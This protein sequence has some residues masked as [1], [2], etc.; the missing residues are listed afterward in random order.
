LGRAVCAAV[1]LV[2]AGAALA[3]PSVEWTRQVTNP[4]SDFGEAVA[5]DNSGRAYLAGSM[6]T[7]SPHDAFLAQNH[8]N[9]TPQ[10]LSTVQAGVGWNEMGHAAA[11]DG[12][13]NVWL[14]GHVEDHFNVYDGFVYQFDV[15]TGGITH[16]TRLFLDYS[17]V[18]GLCADGSGSAYLVATANGNGYLAKVTNGGI[19]WDRSFALGA[20]GEGL[21][22]ACDGGGN[23]YVA[24]HQMVNYG[25]VVRPDV[26]VEK[27]SS[28]GAPVWS[29]SFGTEWGE[30]GTTIACD[31]FGNVYVGGYATGHFTQPSAGGE[32]AFIL[33]LDAAD[34]TEQWGRQF[35][36]AEDEALWALACDSA[37]VL[38]VTGDT[39]GDL[40]GP[41]L[42][43]TDVFHGLVTPDGDIPWMEQW[44]T[45]WFDSGTGLCISG[46]DMYLAFTAGN[47]PGGTDDDAC[48]SRYLIA[49]PATRGLLALG[50]LALIRRRR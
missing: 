36:T 15:A 17:S 33:K 44:G 6:W 47:R 14:G 41:N 2:S 16:Q 43:Y 9:G 28:S 11:A 39:R 35:G 37:G 30:V 32:D 31:N 49:E 22:V 19:D 45:A 24:G 18:N 48:M 50:G 13:G 7:T 8:A 20:Y 25:G 40:A 10:W 27:Y 21:A 38:Y 1:V 23:V 12:L 46:A 26:L 29:R 4:D 5:C 42:G 3:Q 34:G